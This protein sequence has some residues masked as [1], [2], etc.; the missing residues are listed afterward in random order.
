[1]IEV[2]PIRSGGWGAGPAFVLR[3]LIQRCVSASVWPSWFR[4]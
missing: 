1:M 3:K 4:G 2:G